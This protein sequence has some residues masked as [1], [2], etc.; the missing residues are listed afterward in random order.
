MGVHACGHGM[1]GV[2]VEGIGCQRND[3]HARQAQTGLAFAGLSGRF[4]AVEN[5][6]TLPPKDV[7]LG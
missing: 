1:R 4:V 5:R 6:L 7:V 3:G 2:F